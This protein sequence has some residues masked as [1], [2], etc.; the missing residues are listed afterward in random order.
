MYKRQS[1]FFCLISRAG[2][3]GNAVVV[4]VSDLG[5]VFDGVGD[6]GF[7]GLP[8]GTGAAP[9]IVAAA[10]DLGLGQLLAEVIFCL[11]GVIQ[12]PLGYATENLLD[13]RTVDARTIA[14]DSPGVLGVA[15]V[16]RVRE[17][18]GE[19]KYFR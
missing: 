14:F 16:I 4:A 1:S 5:I 13:R 19:S 2:W 7:R 11:I 18:S 8:R 17:S 3:T 10:A 9:V 6:G 12:D 15:S